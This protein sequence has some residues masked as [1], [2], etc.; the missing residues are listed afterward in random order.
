MKFVSIGI[1]ALLV[2]G[3][4][5]PVVVDRFYKNSVPAV[6]VLERLYEAGF[7]VYS[8]RRKPAAAAGDV[9]II[10]AWKNMCVPDPVVDI[11]RPQTSQMSRAEHAERVAALKAEAFRLLRDKVYADAQRT[12][13]PNLTVGTSACV[14]YEPSDK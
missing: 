1:A 10:L 6:E 3:C 12:T 14:Y 13:A 5:C 4:A 8:I 7:E 9:D 2:G 11:V